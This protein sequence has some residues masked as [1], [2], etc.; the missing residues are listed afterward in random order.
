MEKGERKTSDDLI[1]EANERLRSPASSTEIPET[2][3]DDPSIQEPMTPSGPLVYRSQVE[4]AHEVD[5]VPPDLA[6]TRP[7]ASRPWIRWVLSALIFGGIYLFSSF[8][9]ASRD[10]SGEIVG[11]GDVGVMELRVGDCFNDPDDLEEVV[12]DVDAVPCTEAH[13][14]E[15][16]A[17]QSLAGAF[18]SD[19]F[20]GDDPLWE[21]SYSQCSGP[22]FDSYVGTPYLDSSLEVFTFT[23]TEKP[24][25]EGDRE[26]LCV[27]YRLDSTPMNATARGS[28]L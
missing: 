5:P 1:R 7:I 20:P 17:V 6:P 28:G 9:D 21:Y 23:P 3:F 12:Y 16:F 4:T 2:G 24:W 22:V 18:S 19:L 27:L 14:N 15:V 13:D 10:D 25:G 8:G 11:E 26:Y